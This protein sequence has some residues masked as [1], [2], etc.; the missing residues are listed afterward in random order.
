MLK[1][2]AEIESRKGFHSLFIQAFNEWYDDNA[3]RMSA[4]LAFYTVLSLS[5]LL[6]L[7]ISIAGTFYGT[8]S[9]R[10]EI[11][12]QFSM[13]VGPENAEFVNWILQKA[14]RPLEGVI[15][16]IVSLITLAIG[17]TGAFAELQSTID[18]VWNVKKREEG[19]VLSFLRQRFL[20]FLAIVGSSFLL[21]VSLVL[22]AAVAA[23]L[24]YMEDVTGLQGVLHLQIINFLVSFGL[25]FLLFAMI[26]LT[27]PS[28]RLEWRD[29]WFGA[30][31]TAVL[32][33]LGKYAFGLY[34]GR[35]A[36]SSAFGA[37]GSLVAIMM[38]VYFSA[39]VLF[40]GAEFSQVYA[41]RRGSLRNRKRRFKNDAVA[42]EFDSVPIDATS[43]PVQN[44]D[45]G[46]A[47]K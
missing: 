39:I 4:A 25:A 27:L 42:I 16:T 29:V 21:L 14:N 23:W 9:A 20:S 18:I 41:K 34:L 1:T 33:S 46:S 32:F 15:G 12:R 37:A 43:L 35:T 40:Y 7:V 26:F 3:L 44:Q 38:W 6:L 17:A 8:E 13:L 31:I 47:K 30:F 36:V 45:D 11:V 10:A 5:P 24:R 19:R 28:V 22:H 2:Q